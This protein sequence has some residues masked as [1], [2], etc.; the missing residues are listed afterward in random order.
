VEFYLKT[1]HRNA[2]DVTKRSFVY[3]NVS[4]G[5]LPTTCA[6]SRV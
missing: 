2:S 4:D 6:Y 3:L 5:D 1:V